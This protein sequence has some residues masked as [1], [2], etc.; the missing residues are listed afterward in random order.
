MLKS[1][2]AAGVLVAST[3]LAAPAA[4]VK[5]G[6]DIV[7]FG[8]Y[9]SSN[10]SGNNKTL[11]GDGSRSGALAGIG[12]MLRV[13]QDFGFEGDL[14]LTQKGGEGEVDITDYTGV[15]SGPTIVGEGTTTP[16]LRRDSPPARRAPRNR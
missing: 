2:M 4:E 1:I 9:A 14:R 13:N 6:S 11:L 12:F 3:A 7:L 5:T 8:G 10:F 16:H 15:N